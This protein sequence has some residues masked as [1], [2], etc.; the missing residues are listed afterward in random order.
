MIVYD[1]YTI[2]RINCG[3]VH[4][5]DNIE[6]LIHFCNGY[7]FDQRLYDLNF[8]T[9]KDGI[10]ICLNKSGNLQY[11]TVSMKGYKIIPNDF[12][13]TIFDPET[14]DVLTKFINTA[15]QNN[16]HYLLMRSI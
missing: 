13:V 4:Y 9:S 6:N 2:F 7:N 12:K 15:V 14:N 11:M 8:D 16:K 1:N 10:N 3:K 5:L